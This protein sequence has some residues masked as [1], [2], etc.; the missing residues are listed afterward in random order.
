MDSS[1]EA[2]SGHE[3]GNARDLILGQKDSGN[4]VDTV[5]GPGYR[6]ITDGQDLDE[7]D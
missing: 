7:G 1:Y 5:L 6:M 3:I 2:A 4:E